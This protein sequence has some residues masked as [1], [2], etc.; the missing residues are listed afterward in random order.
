MNASKKAL[1]KA[2]FDKKYDDKAL[3]SVAIVY[4]C[5]YSGALLY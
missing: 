2:N 1:F 3:V 4:V 5:C